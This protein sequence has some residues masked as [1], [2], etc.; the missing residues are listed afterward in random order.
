MILANLIFF[1][2]LKSYM[3]LD[4]LLSE[5][6]DR[7]LPSEVDIFN[8]CNLMIDILISE[9]N[10]IQI[11]S[12][13]T[14]CGDIHGQYNDLL[15]MFEVSGHY[16]Q[17]NYLFLGDYVD[18]GYYSLETILYLFLIKI[19]YP[20]RIT[21]LRGNH[22][23]PEINTVYG[24]YEECVKKST[25]Q[26][27]SKINKVF[28]HLPLAA[29]I[30]NSIFCV[31]GG[32][33]PNIQSIDEIKYIN[34]EY[35]IYGMASDLLWSDP[36]EDVSL[37]GKSS[38]GMG[39]VYGMEAVNNFNLINKTSLIC[40]SHQLVMDG[41]KYMFDKKLVTIWSAPNYC[42]RCNNLAAVLKVD[43]N[44]RQFITYDQKI[45]FPTPELSEEDDYES[46]Y[47]NT[48]TEEIVTAEIITELVVDHDIK[49]IVK[50]NNSSSRLSRSP[51]CIDLCYISQHGLSKHDLYF[52]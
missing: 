3:D 44:E 24:F 7:Q 16:D 2:F 38:R 6:H 40:R 50:D 27:W 17:C 21:L 12:P 28:K 48:I 45:M 51:T 52:K 31:H 49:E 19:R 46:A 5:L 8:I 26:V 42:F 9:P 14:I 33:S 32:I 15:H 43:G 23:S 39:Y 10:L 20:Q 25:A 4:K 30:D 37:W 11:S 36:S 18:R 1:Y 47:D 29:I 34:K 22:E 13:V 35:N 41:Y